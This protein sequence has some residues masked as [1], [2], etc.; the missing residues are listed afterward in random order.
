[1]KVLISW[2]SLL[3]HQFWIL[4][5]MVILMLGAAYLSPPGLST[6]VYFD[7]VSLMIFL[8]FSLSIAKQILSIYI[9]LFRLCKLSKLVTFNG[10][11]NFLCLD[12]SF[13]SHVLKEIGRMWI[14]SELILTLRMESGLRL[15][16]RSRV[17]ASPLKWVMSLKPCF[18]ATRKNL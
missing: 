14:C 1:M 3:L 4:I 10:S 11:P 5:D 17:C 6:F 9:L 2:K 16:W 13:G 18:M 15:N 8:I 7:R 12:E